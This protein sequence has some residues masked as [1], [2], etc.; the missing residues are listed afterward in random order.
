MTGS[1]LRNP[2]N[3]RSR[4]LC[5]HNLCHNLCSLCRRSLYRHRSRSREL[6]VPYPEAILCSPCRRGR[7]SPG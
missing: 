5:R 1:S 3:L 4:N 6:A 7:T 2:R